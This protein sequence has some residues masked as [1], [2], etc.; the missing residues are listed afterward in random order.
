MLPSDQS[1]YCIYSQPKH[2]HIAAAGLRQITGVEVYVPRLRFRRA[3][4]RGAVWVTE[5]L[6]PSYLF[7]R[8][9]AETLLRRVRSTFGV[10]TLVQFGNRLALAP[11]S[12]ISELRR[13][14]GSEEICTVDSTPAVGDG[15]KI[16]TG[17]FHGLT[18]VVTQVMPSRER[19]KVLLDFLGRATEVELAQA[20]VVRE[21]AHPLSAR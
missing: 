7:A 9:D 20:G 1:W 18:A 12:A 4:R 5:A 11:D 2:E 21:S 19:V 6:F 8:F 17:A 15:V 13:R 16:C 14:T 10:R 3:T